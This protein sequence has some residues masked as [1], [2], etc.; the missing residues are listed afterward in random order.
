MAALVEPCHDP[1]FHC[2]RTY[3]RATEAVGTRLIKTLSGCRAN[4]AAG[5][6]AAMRE[7]HAA[8]QAQRAAAAQD[9]ID[10]LN[11][12]PFDPEV[13]QPCCC[14]LHSVRLST[15]RAHTRHLTAHHKTPVE[16]LTAFLR[17]DQ[18]L[19]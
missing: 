9:E 1:S 12:D 15:C 7:M 2:C 14:A 18:C 4:D 17:D 10:M 6:A 5:F 19:C 13:R 8:G 16:A 11:A 3:T